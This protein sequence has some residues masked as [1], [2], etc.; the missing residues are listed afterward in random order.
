MV[1]RPLSV[2]ILAVALAIAFSGPGWAQGKPKKPIPA[3][4]FDAGP[5]EGEGPDPLAPT[6]GPRKALIAPGAPVKSAEPKPAGEVHPIIALVRQRLATPLAKGS[7]GERDDYAALAAF[8]ADGDGQPVW[9]SRTG[10]VQRA[11]DA[12][13]ELRKADDWGLRA[14]DYDVPAVDSAASFEML[15]DAEIK[16]SLALMR[17]GRHARGGRLDPRSLSKLFDQDPPVYEPKSLIAALSVAEPIDAYLRRLHPQHPQFERL[18]QA[19]LAARGTKPQANPANVRIPSGPQLKT[20]QDHADVAL[21]RQRLSVTVPAGGKDSVY[22]DA[23]AEA[24]KAFQQQSGMK[25]TGIVN[26]ATRNAL[27]DALRPSGAESVHKLI[28]NMERWRWMPD[29]LGQFYVWDSVPEQMTKIY[30]QGKLVLA[31]RIVVGKPDT[32]T[33]IFSANMLFVIFH[34]SWGVPPGMKANELLPQLQDAGWG[35]FG[36]G[37]ASSVLEAHGLRVTRGGQPV[38]PNNITWNAQTIQQYEFVQ[39]PGPQNVLGM[40]KFRFPNKHNVYMHDTPERNL[41]GGAIRA[42]SHGCMRVQ[43]PVRFAE[44]LLTHDKGW[45][46]DNVQGYAKRGGEIK[47]TT[48]I[49]VHVTYFTAVVDDDGKVQHWPD[50]YA[51]DA[52]VASALGA[53]AG[54]MVTGAV[55]SSASSTESGDPAVRPKARARQKTQ[56]SSNPFAGLFGN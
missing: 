44:V 55:T 53:P 34:P 8:Y 48:P 2:S 23:L 40:V 32:P 54:S 24:V 46:T 37:G 3:I 38:N 56:E 9:T 52:R 16:I 39:P 7:A 31:E 14:A 19:M 15:A 50:V 13:E 47:L 33:P 17:Y 6:D 26:T 22:D 29:P 30:D 49:P 4:G 1:L 27:N 25:P 51:L 18:R 43:N 45:A 21:L 5:A 42:F 20:G 36:F 41:F 35:F 28:V 10:L 11:K 12:I